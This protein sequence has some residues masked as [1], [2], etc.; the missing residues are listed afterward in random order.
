MKLT[1]AIGAILLGVATATSAVAGS[2]VRDGNILTVSGAVDFTM[3][4]QWDL[5]FDPNEITHVK[6]NSEGG[7]VYYGTLIA[8]DVYDNRST[9]YTEATGY[10]AS[11]C[12][13]I[14]LAAD[15][16]VYNFNQDIGFHVSSITD[17]DYWKDRMFE[18]GWKNVE[19]QL[20]ITA[21]ED[22]VLTF[23]YFDNKHYFGEFMQGVADD[24]GYAHLLFTPSKTQLEQWEGSFLNAPAYVDD[25]F[26]PEDTGWGI[27]SNG[28]NVWYKG[29]LPHY[30][31]PV[32][33]TVNGNKIN[34]VHSALF[35]EDGNQLT[36]GWQSS[37]ISFGYIYYD[38]LKT[39]NTR[40]FDLYTETKP[41][42]L[43]ISDA[44]G[45]V[46]RWFKLR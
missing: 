31:V 33:F 11:M 5:L 30:R 44:D 28:P 40:K 24:G 37:D 12:A 29:N 42:W 34:E 14:W 1:T 38:N 9:V 20:K 3:W 21:I 32:S 22:M 17:S 13:Q 10:C 35:D 18:W 27:T 15:K 6:L 36:V 23:K 7:Q 8:D 45:N 19:A 43:R 46:V 41:T 26:E 16:H 39:S 2:V 4:Q 25:V